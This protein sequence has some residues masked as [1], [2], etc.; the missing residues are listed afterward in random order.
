MGP[1]RPRGLI[2][3]QPVCAAV[4]NLQTGIVGAPNL[5][6]VLYLEHLTKE[7]RYVVTKQEVCFSLLS[8]WDPLN[9][10]CCHLVLAK[11]LRSELGCKDFLWFS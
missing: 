11:Q 6:S 5:S 8:L 10:D 1:D 2:Q 4:I 3:L 9:N 7:H